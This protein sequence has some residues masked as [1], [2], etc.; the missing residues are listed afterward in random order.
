MVI[1]KYFYFSTKEPGPSL[2]LTPADVFGN[3]MG[4]PTGRKPR[5]V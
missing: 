3:I 4:K 5:W 1:A 2:N